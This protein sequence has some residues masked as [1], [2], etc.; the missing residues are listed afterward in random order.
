MTSELENQASLRTLARHISRTNQ[1][2]QIV[3]R[4]ALRA[5]TGGA[6][7]GGAFDLVAD[8]QVVGRLAV[9]GDGEGLRLVSISDTPPPVP[10]IPT[11][12]A[13]SQ[14]VSV[15]WNG[16]FVAANRPGDLAYVDI[17]RSLDP[18]FVPSDLTHCGAF[19][20][21]WGGVYLLPALNSD[22]VWY[23]RLV[24]VDLAGNNSEGSVAVPIQASG[25]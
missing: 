24:A 15:S 10:N 8:G 6:L 12:Q 9:T 22:G 2:L 16:T 5:T 7:E 21:V 25:G 3:Q 4:Q 18:A 11:V 23:I 13:F 17:H 1:E 20:S 14:A 19:V